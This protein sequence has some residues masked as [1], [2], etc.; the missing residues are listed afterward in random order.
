MMYRGPCI[1]REMIFNGWVG[2]SSPDARRAI[3]DEIKEKMLECNISCTVIRVKG[4]TSKVDMQR[5]SALRQAAD[6]LKQVDG[7]TVCDVEIK[8][9]KRGVCVKVAV[10][11]WHGKRSQGNGEYTSEC[12][13]RVAVDADSLP[14]GRA[15]FSPGPPRAEDRLSV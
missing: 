15:A 8:W 13:N 10:A 3:L 14:G 2:V 6:K 1:K 12:V 4:A 7:V 9:S 11:F 5:D